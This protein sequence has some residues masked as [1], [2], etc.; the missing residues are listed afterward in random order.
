V[1]TCEGLWS[2]VGASASDPVGTAT[3]E[4]ITVS[5]STAAS[6]AQY[7][8]DLVVKNVTVGGT[9]ATA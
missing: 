9:P 6:S 7:F 4:N 5:T 3:L 8:T 1:D 2:I